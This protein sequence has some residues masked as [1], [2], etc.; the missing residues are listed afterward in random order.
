ML[1]AAAAAIV[2]TLAAYV[3]RP[4]WLEKAELATVDARFALR[5][6]DAPGPSIVIVDLDDAGLAAL[7]GGRDRIPRDSCTRG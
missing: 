4:A 7:G 2:L 3:L 5:G 6:D 1:A